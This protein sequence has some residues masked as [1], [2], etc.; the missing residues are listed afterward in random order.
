MAENVRGSKMAT[1]RVSDVIPFLPVPQV[2]AK[3]PHQPKRD[4]FESEEMT[5]ASDVPNGQTRS[6]SVS[7]RTGVIE[8]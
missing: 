2:S 5:Y 1:L 3:L 7:I 4:H 6:P 8:I